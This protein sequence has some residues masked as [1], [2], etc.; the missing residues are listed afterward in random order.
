MSV[1]SHW[2]LVFAATAVAAASL[3]SCNAPR[4]G[5]KLIEA[6]GVSYTTCT[7]FF[8]LRNE[9]DFRNPDAASYEVVFTDADGKR[10][11]LKRVRMLYT[12]DLPSDTRACAG[13]H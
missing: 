9:G 6:D 12:R 10:H 2:S 3:S 8:A 7:G 11:D 4:A 1:K 5:P 13:S